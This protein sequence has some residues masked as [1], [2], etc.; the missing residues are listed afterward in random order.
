MDS[1]T[2]PHSLSSAL[3]GLRREL[4][5]DLGE[6][7]LAGREGQRPG[8]G[9]PPGSVGRPVDRS[10]ISMRWSCLVPPGHVLEPVGVEVG[11]QLAVEHVEHVAVELGGDPGGVVVGGTSRAR[12]LTRSVPS[13]SRSPTAITLPSSDRGTRAA[14]RGRGCRW[15][16]RGRRTAGSRRWAAGRGAGGSRPPPRSTA[17]PGVLLGQGGGRLPQGGVAHV[18]GDE[19][20]RGGRWTAWRRAGRATC[21]RCRRPAP[22][23]CRPR[24][25]GRCPWRGR[26]GWTARTGS[27]STRGAG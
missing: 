1:T 19:A 23:A 20:L 26:R 7:L 21:R 8:R 4:G 9:R 2:N 24:T 17:T 5:A 22:P 10:H 18:Q 16:R 3:Q 12:S 27:G 15:C 14:G 25:A 13:S 11:A 6:H